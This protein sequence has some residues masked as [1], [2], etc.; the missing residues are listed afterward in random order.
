MIGTSTSR[1]SATRSRTTLISLTGAGGTLPQG[2]TGQQG[3]TAATG[4]QGATGATGQRGAT[5]A[6]VV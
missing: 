6:S 3:A 5:A 2:P 1:S 4:Q